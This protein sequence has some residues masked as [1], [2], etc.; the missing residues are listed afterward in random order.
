MQRRKETRKVQKVFAQS[1][2]AKP[3]CCQA[4]DCLTAL[5]DNNVAKVFRK[6]MVDIQRFV[7][8]ALM[9]ETSRCRAML[10]KSSTY[11]RAAWIR[12]VSIK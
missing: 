9:E 4:I 1:F 2:M 6:H 12:F 3:A 7:S 10:L 11:A 8:S 5:S